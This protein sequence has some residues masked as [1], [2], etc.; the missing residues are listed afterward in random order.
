MFVY[1][2]SRDYFQIMIFIICLSERITGSSYFHVINILGIKRNY[3]RK[4][5][6]KYV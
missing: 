1:A 4:C 2:I 5:F 3:L 6:E